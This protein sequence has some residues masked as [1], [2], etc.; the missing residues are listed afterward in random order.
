MET[1]LEVACP[2]NRTRDHPLETATAWLCMSAREALTA[3][4][5]RL[6]RRFLQSWV[7]AGKDN[8]ALQ[9]K[10]LGCSEKGDICVG[11]SRDRI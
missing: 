3:L 5:T 10:T 2:G 11:M 8:T 7:N 1:F 6:S 9:N 4:T